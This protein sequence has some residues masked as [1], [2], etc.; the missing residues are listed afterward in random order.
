VRRLTSCKY[1]TKHSHFLTNRTHF[2]G[3]MS[4]SSI[5]KLFQ[6]IR[7][8]TA[9]LQHRVVLAPMT[10]TYPAQIA[11]A[12]YLSPSLMMFERD[13]R[14][15]Q[16]RS[17]FASTTN[18]ASKR[19]LARCSYAALRDQNLGPVSPGAVMMTYRLAQSDTTVTACSLALHWST[20]TSHTQ[21]ARVLCRCPYTEN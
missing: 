13:I 14:K 2:R 18:Q 8:G 20:H 11:C 19:R 17:P 3:P 1:S 7:V 4:T 6:P 5:P 16:E 15:R 21:T 9:N 12:K 10:H